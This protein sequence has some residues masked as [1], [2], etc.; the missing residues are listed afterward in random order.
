MQLTEKEQEQIKVWAGHGKMKGSEIL[1]KLN[2]KREARGETLIEKSTVYRFIRGETH[3]RSA[4]ETRGR[5]NQLRRQDIRKLQEARR[6]LCRAADSEELVTWQHVLDEADLDRTPSLRVVQDAL[7]NE[8]VRFRRPR[9]KIALTSEDAKKRYRVALDWKKKPKA[10]WLAMHGYYDNK[11]FPLP[12]TPAQVTKLKQTR[13]TGH[14]RTPE[15]GVQKGFTKPRTEHAWIGFPS[16]TISA[17]VAINR[18]I[19]WEVVEGSWNGQKAADIYKGPMKK[20]LQQT[21]GQKRFYRIIEDG[22]RK[23]NQSNKGKRAKVSAKIRAITLPPRSPCWMPLDFAI[24]DKI[25]GRVLSGAPGR[26]ETKPE[27][28][29]RLR[30]C[31]M[32]LPR[33]WVAK[34]IGRMKKQIDGVVEA[35]GYHPKSD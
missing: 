3:V 6:R 23:G 8:G 27:F 12:L 26:A 31:A 24:W 19:M 25:M 28:L 34:Q 10:Y 18:I 33:A 16:V 9:K 15:E 7:R 30:K 1:A 35:K 22:D 13:I 11:A 4:S 17:V 2:S 21:W 32:S 20:A 5:P 14:L 29:R